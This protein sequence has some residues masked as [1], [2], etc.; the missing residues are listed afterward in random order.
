MASVVSILINWSYYILTLYTLDTSVT[1]D[2]LIPLLAFVIVQSNV[3][4]LASLIYY[5]QYYRLAR[6]VEGSVYR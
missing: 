2:E 1:A 3:P 5:M 4:R 6:M